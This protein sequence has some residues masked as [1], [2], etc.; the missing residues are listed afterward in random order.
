MVTKFCRV[1]ND[2]IFIEVKKLKQLKH[3]TVLQTE[4]FAVVYDW[5]TNAGIKLNKEYC[6]QEITTHADYL[7]I[8]SIVDFLDAGNMGYQA[9]QADASYIH[10]F[11]YPLLAHIKKPGN[12]CLQIISNTAAWDAQKE[13]TQHWSGIT[14]FPEKT[15]NWQNKENNQAIKNTNK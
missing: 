13:T 11:N 8:T 7:A 3:L 9:V 14:I 15:T 4:L 5:L 12:E 6:R 10:E 1:N 2:G